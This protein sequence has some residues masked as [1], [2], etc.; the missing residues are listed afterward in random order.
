MQLYLTYHGVIYSKKNSKKIITNRKTGRPM[1]TSNDNAKAMEEDMAL[2][3]QLQA[4]DYDYVL[5]PPLL[6]KIKIWEKDR[7]RRDLDN[8]ATSVLD[9]LVKAR[10]LE[11]DSVRVVQKLKVELAGYDKKNP[12]AEIIIGSVNDEEAIR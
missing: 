1:I 2:Q 9:A 3:F 4:R 12:R 11:D 8:Q 6:V 7:T 5:A 10:V